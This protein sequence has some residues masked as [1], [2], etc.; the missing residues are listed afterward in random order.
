LSANKFKYFEVTTTSV[1]QANNKSDA[2][3]VTRGKRGVKGRVLL[4]ES[5]TERIT[6]A[7]AHSAV[8][9]TSMAEIS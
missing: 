3:A 4:R 8:S 1:V 2:V 9:G 7:E 6:A 5:T